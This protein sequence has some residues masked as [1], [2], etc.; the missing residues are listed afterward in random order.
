MSIDW[1]KRQ[2]TLGKHRHL[3]ADILDLD[4]GEQAVLGGA[5]TVDNQSD[6]PAAVTTI[7]APGAD[8]SVPGQATL[9]GSGVQTV[10]LLGPYNV[11]FETP[12]IFTNGVLL[13]T[14]PAGIIVISSWA[15]PTA[16]FLGGTVTDASLEI[17]VGVQSEFSGVPIYTAHAKGLGV[18]DEAQFIASWPPS[19]NVEAGLERVQSYAIRTKT[20]TDLYMWVDLTGAGADQGAADIY[21]LIGTPS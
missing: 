19:V 11:T 7:V 2:A 3:A 15:E 5:M 12:D 16:M 14:L 8:V 10:T 6:P 1:D 21:V 4:T 13:D 20:E 9:S 18:H 17:W